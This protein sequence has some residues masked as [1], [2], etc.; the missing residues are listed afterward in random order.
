MAED[1]LILAVL[2]NV[3]IRAV[4]SEVALVLDE[5]CDEGLTQ[6]TLV[7]Y[8]KRAFPST[9]LRVLLA[10]SGWTRVCDGALSDDDFNELLRP[11]V[12]ENQAPGGAEA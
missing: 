7:T 6:G 2:R 10:A 11:R 9:P 8:F 5:M 1:Q 3:A 4:P 12:N